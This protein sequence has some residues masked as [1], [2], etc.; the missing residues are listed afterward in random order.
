MRHVVLLG[1]DTALPFA[2][3]DDLTT[4]ANE[5]DY[6]STFARSDD[7]YG[8]LFEH[9]VLSDDP[10][11][12]TDPIPYLQRQ[13]FVPQLAV[14]RLV[15]TAG[16]ITGTL[17]RFVTFGG[18]L[19][20]ASARTSG[21][22]F[23]QDGADGVAAAFAGIVGAPQPA[24]TPPLIG[25]QWTATTLSGALGTNTGLFG[26]NGHADHHRLQPAAGAQLFSAAN[27]PASLERSVVFSMG[28]HS[29]L[30][31]SDA[32]VAGP[33][34]T[35]WAQTFAGKGTAA[36][37]GNLGY[38]YGDTV[39]AAYS[40]ALNVRLAQGLRNGLPIGEA[41]IEAKQGYLA[42]LGLVGVYDEK[43]MS[44]LALYGLPMWSLAGATPPPQ[45]ATPV[46]PAGVTRLSTDPD[47]V[48]GLLVDR[49][50]SQP[51]TTG[52]N[53]P[54]ERINRVDGSSYWKGPSGVQVTHL[55][56]LQ[57]KAEFQVAPD[58]HGML[59][60]GLESNDLPNIDPV[61]ARPI[62]DSSAAEPELPFADVAFPAKI[63]SLVSQETR[64]GR[65]VSAVLVH[66]QFFSDDTVDED[67]AGHQR[68]FTR[69]D[70]DV[71]RSQGIDRLAPRFD[72][73]EAVVLPGPGLV[74]FSV[75]AVD[76]PDET[77]TGVARVLVAFRDE[78]SA[79]WRFLDLRRDA[80]SSWGGSASVS[81]TRIEYFVQAADRSGN[82][83][84]STNK[85]LLFAGVPPAPPSGTGVEPSITPS[86]G[87]TQTAGWFTPSAV[88]DVDAAA[89][90]AVSVSIDGGT[91]VPFSAPITIGTDRLHKVE[92]RGSNGY[93]AT[94][95]APVDTLPPTV[96]L[97]GPGATV[98]LNGQ[99]PLAF[100][101]GDTAS[102]VASCVAKVDGVT[103]APGFLV[104]TTPLGSPHTIQLTATDRVG[105]TTTQTFNYT[106]ASRGIVY[107]NN[108]TGSG[109][110]YVLPVN[111]GPSTVPTRL[112]ATSA[113]ETDPVWSPDSRRIAFAS[114]R[115]G[116]WRIYLMD[117]DGTDV[118][119]LPTGTGNALDPAWS[120]DGTRIA[121]VSNRSGN[122]D[123]WVVKLDGTE[124]RRLTTD[125]N[126][127]LAP[128]WSQQATNQIAWANGTILGFDI[129]KMQADGTGKAR[130]T[131]SRDTAAES[132]WSRDG[133]IAFARRPKGSLRSEIWTMTTAGTSQTRILSTLRWDLQPS[134]LQDGKL[135]FASGRDAD[136]DF[137]L[138]RATKVGT[139]WSAVRV[140]NA[141]GNDK[142]PN[143]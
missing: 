122:S 14:G 15:E 108:D 78:T 95:L 120:P 8:A 118:T 40:E 48:T 133:T 28:C 30:S 45:P 103:Q 42:G 91:L 136:H 56:P 114:N 74:S 2:R 128:T 93:E 84:V 18:E 87:G 77:A 130:L 124:L 86:L 101:C 110:V 38:G 99:V 5:A 94:L 141:P 64:T 24:T 32:S 119:P 20:P 112:T 61:Y 60:T 72:A 89:G 90:V 113:P 137:D 36:Y 85:G 33:I 17:E 81:G 76:L 44:E 129:W 102:G 39:T 92:V 98:P 138:Y 34:S 106:V 142:T 4:I 47:P 63:Q 105:R 23:L 12:T 41:L 116:T 3:L 22:D 53:P 11:G 111:A 7:L 37:A 115:D 80:G 19:D 65:R 97:D 135:V 27:L 140:T 109:D 121:F 66:G 70:L 25:N 51:P 75:N 132:S 88:L 50:R 96:R 1:N 62:V 52:T 100:M 134:W 43:A 143:G 6:A 107:I 117:A 58:A 57:P 83:A 79:T 73:I 71:L 29:G 68:L 67:G 9:R 13:L 59:I 126:L 54:L 46:L 127:D 139:S 35:D 10:Y 82:V 26:M 16:Q 21:Y 49:Y 55:R 123:I 104:P 69:V 131:T 125:S 31:A